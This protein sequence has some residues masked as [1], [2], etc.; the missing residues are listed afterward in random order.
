MAEENKG[1][2]CNCGIG[3]GIVII[4]VGVLADSIGLGSGLPGYG[5]KQIAV[6][7]LGVAILLAGLLAGSNFCRCDKK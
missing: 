2:K 7:A 3:V 1:K 6:I 5:V 4:V